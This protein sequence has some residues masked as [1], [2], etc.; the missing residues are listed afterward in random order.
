MGEDITEAVKK[1]DKLAYWIKRKN[2]FSNN[3]AT[4]DSLRPDYVCRVMSAEDSYVTGE[5]HPAKSKKTVG[6]HTQKGGF[7]MTAY[8]L[9]RGLTGV[10]GE[11]LAAVEP[12]DQQ[13]VEIY[14]RA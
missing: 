4:Q 8:Q 12:V 11:L 3:V 7:T 1:H 10:D 2:K 9:F 6:R 5:V 13:K 14:L